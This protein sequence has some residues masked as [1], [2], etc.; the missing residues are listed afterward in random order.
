MAFLSLSGAW[1]RFTYRDKPSESK[2]QSLMR[3]QDLAHSRSRSGAGRQSGGRTEPSSECLTVGEETAS[4]HGISALR[5]DSFRTDTSSVVL[6]QK[7]R[8]WFR[9]PHDE[10]GSSTWCRFPNRHT[11]AFSSEL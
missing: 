7:A 6:V 9:S 8:L 10:Q 3:I 5:S 2:A 4:K 1:R 11:I